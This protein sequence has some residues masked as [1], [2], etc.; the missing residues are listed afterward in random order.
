MSTPVKVIGRKQDWLE[1][2]AGLRFR[3]GKALT[4]LTGSSKAEA[5]HPKLGKSGQPFITPS[6]LVT[7]HRLTQERHDLRQDGL[8]SLRLTKKK[9]RCYLQ[10]TLSV[11][12]HQVLP[13]KGTWVEYLSIYPS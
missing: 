5:T 7:R 2:E 9:I 10:T 4:Y 8:Y 3:F 12:G 1:K 13:P 6:C 11:A